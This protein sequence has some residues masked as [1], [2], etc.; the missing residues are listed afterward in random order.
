MN[1]LAI[2]GSPRKGKATDTLVGHA[3]Q[4]VQSIHPD[5][6][7]NKIYIADHDIKYCR[8]CL[9][10]W[11]SKTKG[12]V[13]K[14]AIRDD[15]DQI[16]EE[17]LKADR[18]IMATPVHMGYASALMTTFLERICWTFGKPAKS[19]IIV[20]GCPM[21]RSDKKRKAVIVAVSGMIPSRYKRFC[22]EA[23]PQIRGVIKDSLNADT[24]GRLY[25]G[26][27]WHVGVETY[28]DRAFKLG[29]QLR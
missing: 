1:L 18:L 11:K 26:D 27:V 12:P 10:C 17:I 23:T 15:M 21:P 5:C 28:F 16:N 4:G 14:C 2:I 20:K 13:A 19:Y 9:T 24:V 22:N 6:N 29:A 8:D 3:I 25:A 7:V